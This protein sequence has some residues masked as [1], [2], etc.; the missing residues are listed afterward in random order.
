M[1]SEGSR[2][3]AKAVSARHA[4]VGKQAAD[5]ADA[6][7]VRAI[8]EGELRRALSAC[9]RQHAASIG[10][11]C[12]ALSG[13]QA[14]AD[15][16]TQQTL[17]SAHQRFSELREPSTVGSVRGW[18][19]AI[20]RSKC[21]QHLARRRQPGAP[22]RLPVSVEPSAAEELLGLRKRAARA[23]KLLERLHPHDRD[24]LLLRYLSGLSF[25]DVALACRIDEA[26]ARQR[27]SR[28][29]IELRVAL[30]NEAEND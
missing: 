13:S 8:T 16:L 21:Q 5:A 30:A 11:L 9:V 7:I 12:L 3:S 28:G 1:V 18:L 19:S 10:R 24:A 29:L 15:E 6:D 26:T 2:A 27:A 20:A 14:D 17:I 22:G 25:E 23:R 4:Q